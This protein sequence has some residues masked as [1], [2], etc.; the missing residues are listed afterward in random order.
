MKKNTYKIISNY[1]TINNTDETKMNSNKKKQESSSPKKR[2]S[3]SEN[4]VRD[5][6]R[7]SV[8]DAGSKSENAHDFP[9]KKSYQMSSKS[10][11]SLS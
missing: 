3:Q 6:S 1:I 5:S 10:N 9:Y 7:S 11:R 2:R 8:G 4:S